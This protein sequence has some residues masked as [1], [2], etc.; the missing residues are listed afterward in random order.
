MGQPFAHLEPEHPFKLLRV[1]I[2]L[3]GDWRYEKAHIWH[4]MVNCLAHLKEAV[5]DP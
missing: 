1:H 5:V 4:S 3:T 2:T